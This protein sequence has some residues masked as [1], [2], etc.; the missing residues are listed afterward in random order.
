MRDVGFIRKLARRLRAAARR[1]HHI[2]AFATSVLMAAASPAIAECRLSLALGLDVSGSVDS[3][4]YRLQL[5]GLAAA[6]LHP[7][8]QASLFSLPAVPVQIAVFE[9]SD[10]LHQHL[11]LD[12]VLL[13]DRAA[14]DRVVETLR[15][16]RRHSAP[17]STALGTAMQTGAA[18]LANGP[19]CWKRTLDLSGDGKHNTGPHPRDVRRTLENAGL[20]IN[21]LVVGADAPASGDIRQAEIGAL[22]SYFNA[23]V[24]TG[25]DAFVETALGFQEFEAAMVRK[26]KRELESPV[27]SSLRRS[28]PVQINRYTGFDQS[29][30]A[31]HVSTTK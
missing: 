19:R 9:W 27:L 10:P 2:S 4:E 22:S 14:L 12:W 8:V 13:N 15:N 11:L 25:P 21:A 29:S 26:L 6:L 17:P 1:S 30:T 24:I 16:T 20:T 31:R 5:D 18:L 7:D 3:G 23:W 28:N